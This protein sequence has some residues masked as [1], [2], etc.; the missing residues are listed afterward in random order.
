MEKATIRKKVEESLMSIVSL[1]GAP[2][3]EIKLK[4]DLGLDIMTKII[5]D[6]LEEKK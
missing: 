4:S 1:G 5:L 6:A 2:L 3:E